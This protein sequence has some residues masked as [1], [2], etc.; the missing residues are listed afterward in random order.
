[1]FIL[2]FRIDY[3]YLGPEHQTSENL[4]LHT[5]AL[6]CAGSCKYYKI[7]VLKRKTIKQNQTIIMTINP[8]QYTVVRRQVC[9]NK[10]E[11]RRNGRRIHVKRNHELIVSKRQG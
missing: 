2:H 7:C 5:I 9:G 4:E 10:W 3:D 8:V 1:M 6:P 11:R